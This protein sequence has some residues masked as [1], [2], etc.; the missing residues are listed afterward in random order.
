MVSSANY[1]V[2]INPNGSAH[3]GVSNAIKINPQAPKKEEKPLVKDAKIKYRKIKRSDKY[4][5]YGDWKNDYV[6]E[7]TIEITNSPEIAELRQK[8]RLITFKN[9]VSKTLYLKNC[10]KIDFIEAPQ[11]Y[12]GAGTK[13]VKSLVERS[14][15]DKDTE[16]RVVVNAEI[17]DEKTSPAGFFYKL[18]FRFVDNNQ[19]DKMET[20]IK[21]KTIINAPQLTGMMYLPKENIN[22]LL[23]YK[24]NLL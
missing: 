24:E 5:V 21:E 10:Y 22:K 12:Q 13:A 11:R 9:P 23:R 4:T 17:I 16:G 18:G 8:Y 6:D 19:N 1:N 20:W 3:M 7:V 2:A 14:L 15:A